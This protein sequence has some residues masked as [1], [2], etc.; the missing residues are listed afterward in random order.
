[1]K[2]YFSEYFNVS[3][4]HLDEY[5]A[6]NICL[7]SDLPLFIDPFLLFHS[8]KPEYQKL[9]GSMIRYLRF[10]R[11]KAKNGVL[12]S[13]LI[14]G[15]YEFNEVKQNWLG[16]T[17]FGNDGRGLGPDFA[18]TLHTSLRTI[19]ADFGD[20]HISRGSHLEKVSLLGRGVGRDS[21]SDFTT[22]LIKEYLLSYTEVFAQTY[23][24]PRLCSEFRV[25]RVSFNYDTEAWQDKTFFLPELRGDFVLLTPED[26]LTRDDIWIS[27]DDLLSK[28]S[29]IPEALP[30][31]TLRAQVDNYFQLKLGINPDRKRKEEAVRSTLREYPE[32]LDYYIRMKEEEGDEAESVSQARVEE[33]ALVFVEQLRNLAAELRDRTQFY[34]IGLSSYDEAL[35]RVKAFKDYIENQDG[36]KLISKNG[37]PFAKEA[38]VQLYFGLI[39]Y[40][41]IFDVNREPNN[42]RGPVDFKVSFGSID[43]SLIEFKLASNSKLK[44]NLAKQVEIYEKANNTNQSIKVIICYTA[45]HQKKVEKVLAELRLASK[46]NIVIIDAR[47]DNKPSASTA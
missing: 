41:T 42:G 12:N 10:L 6:F 15:W 44:D 19:L 34:D 17:L 45:E 14:A 26:M 11:D 38:D 23:L 27:H 39:W 33:T 36:Y 25:R 2:L 3:Q 16:F 37:K 21:I 35:A 30:N 1:V 28:F 5:G 7:A 32:I 8:E 18:H 43:K 24:D 31:E 40:G 47:N 9:H 46:N 29:R 13:G 20:E 4:E 22:N